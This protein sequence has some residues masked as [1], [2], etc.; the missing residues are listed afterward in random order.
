[1]SSA[2]EGTLDEHTISSTALRIFHVR[3]VLKWAT[4][5][6]C[7]L[8]AVKY[9]VREMLQR[10]LIIFAFDCSGLSTM[11]FESHPSHWKA[12]S[13][14]VGVTIGLSPSL[15]CIVYGEHCNVGG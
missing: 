14:F 2:C 3:K 11:G 15:G 5:S 8:D 9:G 7:W 1:M 4:R 10:S 6:A 13:V 12:S